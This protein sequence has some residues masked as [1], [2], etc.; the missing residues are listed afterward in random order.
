MEALEHSCIVIAIGYI[1]V[2]VSWE[3]TQGER[4]TGWEQTCNGSCGLFA[5]MKAYIYIC[6]SLI[7]DDVV[8]QRRTVDLRGISACWELDAD[9]IFQS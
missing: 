6:I 2:R 7:R 9:F 8:M 5:V 1:Y 3:V 4:R